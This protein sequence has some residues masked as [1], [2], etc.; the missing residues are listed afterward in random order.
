MG[1][2]KRAQ[3]GPTF[4]RMMRSEREA[5]G[6]TQ[7]Q[8]A[9]EIGTRRQTIADLESGKNVGSHIIFAV[10]AANGKM[11]SISSTRPDLD[12]IRELVGEGD[13]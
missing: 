4:G 12:T 1:A 7:E 5:L 2:I 8:M 13:E 11:V 10:L 9:R 6:K 3:D